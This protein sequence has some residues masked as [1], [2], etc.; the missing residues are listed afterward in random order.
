MHQVQGS[1]LCFG[2]QMIL[3]ADSGSTKTDWCI[4]DEGRIV[5]RMATQGLN[6]FHQSLDTIAQ[7]INDELLPQLDD[8]DM[9]HVERLHF[10]GSGCRAEMLPRITELFTFL[11]PGTD[12]EC[13]GDLM[14]AARAVCG[15]SEGIACIL[16]TGSNSC[17]YDGERVVENVPPLGY[18]L[19]D[20]GSGAVMG[21][22]FFNALYK[23][24]LDDRLRS[25]Y[26][27]A[28]GLIMA[29]VI[30]HVYRQPLANRFLASACPF[31]A[32]HLD[33]S[34]LHALVV[35]NF[36]QFFRRNVLR[37]ERTDLRAGAIGSVAYYF[38]KQL[39]AA[40]ALEGVTIGTV[41]RSPMEGLVHYHC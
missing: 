37:Y 10:Y 16:G 40:A 29:D 5:K 19:G 30:D 15:S 20:E 13:Q 14:A 35:D 25:D 28:T 2:R 4:A 23:G 12:V 22:L 21:R 31:I 38:E 3:I 34:S 7:V 39:C 24:R 36:R 41:V 33:N 1:L 9:V 26:E 27:Q 18:I 8:R 32:K 17:L 11:F 6:P